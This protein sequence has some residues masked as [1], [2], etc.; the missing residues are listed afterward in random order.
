V[1]RAVA[2]LLGPVRQRYGELRPDQATLERVLGQ[3]ADKARAIA[4]ETVAVARERMG[5]GPPA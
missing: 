4:A 1:G 3:G 5:L 2:D